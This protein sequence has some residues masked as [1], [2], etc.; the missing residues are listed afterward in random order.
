L[1][2]L[3]RRT[4]RFA[5]FFGMFELNHNALRVRQR[6]QREYLT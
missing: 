2:G 6:D 1:T 3:I 5:C 4:G